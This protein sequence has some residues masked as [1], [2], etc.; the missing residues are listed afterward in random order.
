[1]IEKALRCARGL[2]LIVALAC[3]ALWLAG[4]AS[5]ECTDTSS[6]KDHFAGT[7]PCGPNPDRGR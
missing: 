4:P 3:Q 1:M 7:D 6:G 5:A 2:M